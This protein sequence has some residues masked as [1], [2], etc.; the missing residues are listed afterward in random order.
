LLQKLCS[1][2]TPH[3]SWWSRVVILGAKLSQTRPV[4]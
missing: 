1:G 3:W 2:A 4:T